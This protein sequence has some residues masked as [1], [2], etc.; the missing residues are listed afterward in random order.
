MEVL[1]QVQRR[2]TRLGK[3]WENMAYEERLRELE[4]FGVG[5]RRQRGDLTA[6][7]QY[8]KGAYGE[9]RA[10]IFSLLVSSHW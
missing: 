2:A 6:L 10:G 5:K 1:E 7:F 9:S 8:L 3:G 4:L